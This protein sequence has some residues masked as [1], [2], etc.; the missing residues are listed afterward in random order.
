[1]LAID[2]CPLVESLE[3]IS[4]DEQIWAETCEY[5]TP[6]RFFSFSGLLQLPFPRSWSCIKNMIHFPKELVISCNKS[7][8]KRASWIHDILW[9]S[10]VL[11]F[12]LVSWSNRH[13]INLNKNLVAWSPSNI[14]RRYVVRLA[15]DPRISPGNALRSK[16]A[17]SH[18]YSVSEDYLPKI[19][20]LPFWSN[21]YC[22]YQLVPPAVHFLVQ[23]SWEHNSP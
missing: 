1:M 2:P 8:V 23:T 17:I 14:L 22:V 6:L 9:D 20:C 5:S 15:R 18:E 16:I 4:L 12:L 21:F 11:F 19:L 7:Q 13:S 3:I 10:L